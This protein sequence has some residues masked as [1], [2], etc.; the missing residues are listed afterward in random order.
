[1]LLA[2]I[3]F[4]IYGAFLGA[5][6]AA[7]FFNSTPIVIFWIILLELLIAGF[8]V[9]RPLT[10]RVGLAAIHSGCI[11]VLAGGMIGS[12]K[13]HSLQNRLFEQQTFT[14]GFMSLH[15][16]QSSSYVSLKQKGEIGQL[17]FSI[18][19]VDAFIEYYDKA[20][21]HL[22]FD[23]GFSFRMPVLVGEVFRIPG[24]RGTAQIVKVYSNFKMTQQNGHMVPYD[25]PEPG[26]NRAYEIVL[27]T[28]ETV[29]IFAFERF[30]MH[31]MPGQTVGA[32]YVGPRMIKDYRSTLQVIDNGELVKEKTIEVNQPLYYGGYHFYQN[33]FAYDRLGPVSGIE[34]V[35]SRGVWAV[36]AGYAV[37]FIGLIL[38]FGGKLRKK[39][40]V[41]EQAV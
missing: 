18:R 30:G 40:T 38:Q 2:L 24:H 23:D 7:R 29:T 37:I 11:L 39:P 32:E 3:V 36:F 21:I 19:L 10:K 12:D 9:Y 5:E 35:T 20:S 22:H 6:S 8:F 1:M 16:G 28:E 15:P 41:M 13:G 4:S 31:T 34:V 27:T 26:D 25:S 14:K 17:P 33:T